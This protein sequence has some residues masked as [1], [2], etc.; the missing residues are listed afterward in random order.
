MS[1]RDQSEFS[2]QEL[3]SF[4]RAQLAGI[5]KGSFPDDKRHQAGARRAWMLNGK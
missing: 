2:S 5:L 4:L 3:D 1:I